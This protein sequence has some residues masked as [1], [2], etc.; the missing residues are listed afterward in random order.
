M[1]FVGKMERQTR[2]EKKR[3]Q[4]HNRESNARK[5]QF[6][7]DYIRHKYSNIY[8]EAEEF[9]DQ[10]KTFYPNK[11]D[12]KK[13]VEYATWKNQISNTKTRRTSTVSKSTSTVSKSTSTVSKNMELKIELINCKSKTTTTQE[14]IEITEQGPSINEEISTQQE[15]IDDL[16]S[17]PAQIMEQ[18]ICPSINEEISTQQENIDD[19]NSAPAEIMEQGICPSINEE[20]STQQE[21]IDDLNAATAEIMKQDIWPSID[22]ELSTELLEHIIADLNTE[23]YLKGILADFE[24]LGADIEIDEQYTLEDELSKY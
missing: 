3:D 15:N 21:N 18:G 19:L 4:R 16:N 9:H 2:I 11:H 5:D 13:T 7:S 24:M 8:S 14:T 12:I 10:L 22:Q 17:A 20:I 23:P 6:I 1:A